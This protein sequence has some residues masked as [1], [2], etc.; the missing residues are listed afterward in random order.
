MPS[1]SNAVERWPHLIRNVNFRVIRILLS[2]PPP[3]TT[4]SYRVSFSSPTKNP[5]IERWSKNDDK[6][7]TMIMTTNGRRSVLYGLRDLRVIHVCKN[8]IST[9]NL[10]GPRHAAKKVK[11]SSKSAPERKI[12]MIKEHEERRTIRSTKRALYYH[13]VAGWRSKEGGT[14]N[15]D[16]GF[17]MMNEWTRILAY[18]SAKKGEEKT[19]NCNLFDGHKHTLVG[20][21]GS[22]SLP[23]C[24]GMCFG[25]SWLLPL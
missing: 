18:S 10:P 2:S 6:T 7:L 15:H 19:R 8:E 14:Q 23:A 17:E 16:P 20:S 12:Y 24:V 21:W 4:T 1:R 11:F 13:P 5:G 22:S 9:P 3:R 25:H